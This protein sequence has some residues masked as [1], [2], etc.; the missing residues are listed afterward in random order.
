MENLMPSPYT[1]VFLFNNGRDDKPL[2]T[3]LVEALER[4]VQ[5]GGCRHC[6]VAHDVEGSG[7]HLTSRTL[8]C[9][10]QDERGMQAAALNM[11]SKCPPERDYLA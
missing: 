7:S 1:L 6:V 10:G 2:P 3:Y 9:A 5:E 4:F 11:L 8:N